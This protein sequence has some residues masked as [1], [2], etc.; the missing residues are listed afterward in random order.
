MRMQC[1]P[2]RKKSPDM[3]A[4]VLVVAASINNINQWRRASTQAVNHLQASKFRLTI[5]QI[6]T[7]STSGRQSAAFKFVSSSC[8]SRF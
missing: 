2:E 4:I 6:F 5:A 8:H 3:A 7:K 1:L